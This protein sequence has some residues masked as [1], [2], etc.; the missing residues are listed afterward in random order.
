[1]HESAHIWING[2]DAGI[3]WSIPFTLRIGKYLHAGKNEIRIEVA[4]LMAN[5]IR[6][7]DQ[8]HIPWRQYHEIN[9]VN[10]NYKDFDASNWSVQPSGLVGKV[11]ITPFN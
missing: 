6:Y 11:T 5:H 3:M 8:H 4:N 9:F 10:I 1:V 2:Q 7:M